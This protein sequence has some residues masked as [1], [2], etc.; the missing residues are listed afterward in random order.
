MLNKPK[1]NTNELK[2]VAEGMSKTCFHCEEAILPTDNLQIDVYE[3]AALSHV[4]ACVSALC[5]ACGEWDELL[6]GRACE[7]EN[8]WL[9]EMEE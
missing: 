4:T 1:I 3:I 8:K 7:Y 2:T 6:T 5:P 9:I